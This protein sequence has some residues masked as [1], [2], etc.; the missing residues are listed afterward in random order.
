MRLQHALDDLFRTGSHIRVLRVLHDL[1]HGVGVSGREIARRA[2]LSAPTARDVLAA[3]VEQGVVR[4]QR[5]LKNAS[6]RL[7]EEHVLVAPLHELLAY[8]S[9]VKDRLE[10]EVAA[11][12]RRKRGVTAAYL[13]GSA[14]RGDMRPTSDIDIAVESRHAFPESD[15]EELFQRRGNRVNVLRLRRDRGRGIRERIR[16]EGKTLPISRR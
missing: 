11:V 8:E 10:R 2:G 9:A 3:L 15:F 4:V 5:S 13:F 16:I 6:Y 14:A 12:L 1:P 7:N